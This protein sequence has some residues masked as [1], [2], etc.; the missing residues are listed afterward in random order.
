[1]K[2]LV[3]GAICVLL[4]SAAVFLFGNG[5][6]G[7]IA[8][9]PTSHVNV[10]SMAVGRMTATPEP[11]PGEIT[12]LEDV[13]VYPGARLKRTGCSPDALK[14]CY[15]SWDS[16]DTGAQIISF[17]ISTLTERGWVLGKRLGS[18]E[19]AWL[20]FTWEGSMTIPVTSPSSP[21]SPPP[22]TSPIPGSPVPLHAPTKAGTSQQEIRVDTRR[23]LLIDVGPDHD[24][25]TTY[26]S[27]SFSL[28]PN[29]RKIP[30]YYDAQD[31]V[32]KAGFTADKRPAWLVTY[33]SQATPSDIEAFYTDIMWQL[34]WR[35][36]VKDG[37]SL[38]FGYGSLGGEVL[39]YGRA[40][41]TL[42]VG[43]D[44][45]TAV[46]VTSEGPDAVSAQTPSK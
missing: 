27:L 1:M 35:T 28:I 4:F 40:T 36:P 16:S 22:D 18:E 7:L 3:F 21:S 17:Y 24:P 15:S 8:S 6:F 2:R 46:K 12:R 43:T 11:L 38:G 44:R 10:D 29:A 39:H 30:M 25:G 9:E 41:I 31:I 5:Y 13:P 33:T 26:L 45:K 20:D 42:D 19:S 14:D 34:G 32:E 37:S 23:R